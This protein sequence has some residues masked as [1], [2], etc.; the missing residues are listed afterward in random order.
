MGESLEFESGAVDGSE[1]RYPD[2]VD[3]GRL[4]E[5]SRTRHGAVPTCGGMKWW[6]EN[7]GKKLGRDLE[8]GWRMC[9]ICG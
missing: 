7:S 5:C 2:M 4:G 8:K 6:G 1:N 9:Y 3:E